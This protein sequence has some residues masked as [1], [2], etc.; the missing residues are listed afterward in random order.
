MDRG[1]LD[2]LIARADRAGVFL[3]F[4]GTLSEIALT[5]EAA[6]A[7]PGA[8]EVLERLAARFAVVA[9]VSGRRAAEVLDRLDDPRGVRI[10]GLYGLE[11]SETEDGVPPSAARAIEGILPSVLEVAA[12]V[13]GTLVEP[14]A[15]NLAIHYRLAP[16]QQEA[17]LALVEALRPL[18]DAAGLALIEGKRVVELTPAGAPSKGDV[19]E[20]EGAGMEAL[21]YAGDD[22]ADLD[23]FGAIDRLVAHGAYAVKVAVASAET[24]PGLLEAADIAVPG[25]AG[26]IE[27]L[28]SLAV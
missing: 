27:L 20:R 24:P 22:L 9:V 12:N 17:R 19:V 14:K 15:A 6:V 7:T 1:K 18:A 4:D 21:L 16:D 25:P 23:A 28:A 10:F 3:D 11:G 5:P 26:L 13:P 8:R 2:V